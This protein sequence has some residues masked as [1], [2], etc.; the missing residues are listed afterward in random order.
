M[1]LTLSLFKPP[2]TSSKPTTTFLHGSLSNTFS[3]L[4][5]SSTSPPPSTITTKTLT[6]KAMKSMQGKVVCATNDKT[7]AVE[8]TRLAPH[9]KYKRRVRKKKRFQAHD[10]DNI[11]KVGDLV[12]LEKCRPIS[13]TK[14]FLAVKPQ[15][16]KVSPVA[17]DVVAPN[18]LGLP[19][20]SQQP[21]EDKTV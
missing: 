1:S 15:A 5:I 3:T 20:Q 18:E 8:V 4:S 2:L 11:F 6:I 16:R 9:P 14:T 17:A 19:L 10:P 12:Q 13:K 7:V 21:D